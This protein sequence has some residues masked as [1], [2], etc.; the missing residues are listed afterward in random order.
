MGS[1][2]CAVALKM[3]QGLKLRQPVAADLGAIA[4]A[5]DQLRQVRKKWEAQNLIS[6]EEYPAVTTD[7]RPRVYGMPRWADMFSPRQLL[8]LGVLVE[9]LHALR[10][11]ILA[12]EGEQ[13]GE[14]IA[15]LLAFAIDKFTNYNN[16]L[17]P[18]H[19]THQVIHGIFD[20]HDFSF[21]PTYTE[22]APVAAGSGLDW[23]IT[24]TIEAEKDPTVIEVFPDEE[25]DE[26]SPEEPLI[27]PQ[28]TETLLAALDGS[29]VEVRAETNT[30]HVIGDGP[31]RIV[32]DA[33]AVPLHSDAACIDGLDARQWVLLRQLQRAGECLPL[34]LVSA[35][36]GAFRTFMC[37]W[38]GSQGTE[39]VNS[40]ADV[41][42][43][44][45]E[46]G[47]NEPAVDAW[48]SARITLDKRARAV[49]EDLRAQAKAVNNRER[50]EQREAARFRLIEELGR[51]L[52]CHDPDTDDLNGKFHRLA[53]DTTPTASQ[54][55]TVFNR[56]GDY[57]DWDPDHLTDLHTFR[58]G[59]SPSQI[60][61]RLTGTE[62][63]AALADPRW[64]VQS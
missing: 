25:P 9:E 58:N 36:M 6:T 18:W 11:K 47:G 37:G 61:T 57:P 19:V 45:A 51:L 54:L 23:A 12:E 17:A 3:P 53:S 50:R 4:A 8:R 42:R 14:A 59:M 2:L 31:L 63:D 22:M 1:A 62:L 39:E 27:R 28:D 13:V 26:L 44:V 16:H 30:R 40:F 41:K 48:N 43:L 46:W 15:H 32:T 64:D 5:E 52:V 21:K 20:R 55:K 34:L 10:P 7:P 33:N 49:V 29:R 24:N 38:V 56:L 60:K 35:E